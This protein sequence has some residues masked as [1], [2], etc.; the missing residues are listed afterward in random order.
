MNELK[1]LVGFGLSAAELVADFADGISFS[2]ISKVVEV[3]KLSK[4][5]IKGAQAALDQYI[6]MSDEEAL[7]L[8]AYVMGEFDI[9]DD[10]VEQAIEAALKVAI[11]L[12]SVV[13]LFAKKA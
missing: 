9:S 12:H 4:P 8:E 10:K 5:A 6:A 2:L 7:S 13:A 3:A 1:A 11:E